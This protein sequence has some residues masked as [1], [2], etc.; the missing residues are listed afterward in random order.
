MAA[1]I[2]IVY[3]DI[4]DEITSAASRIRAAQ[5]V[6]VALVLPAGSRLATSRINFRLLAREAQ[7]RSRQLLIVA[8]EGATRALAASAGLTVFAT[9]RELEEAD[10]TP[11][12]PPAAGAGT[13]DLAGMDGAAGLAAAAGAAGLA[14]AAGAGTA[15]SSTA[16]PPGSGALGRGPKNAAGVQKPAIDTEP[17][18]VMPILA[19]PLSAGAPKRGAPAGRSA[20][21]DLPVAHG[22][23]R[24]KGPRTARLVGGVLLV[25]AALLGGV[26]G[27]V[28]LPSATI[29]LTPRVEAI[30]PLTFTVRADPSATT[31]DPAAATVPALVVTFPLSAS[32]DFPATGKKVTETKATGA[33]TFSSFDQT[34]SNTIPAG[35]IVS[36]TSDTEFV[37]A[38]SVTLPP[39]TVVSDGKLPPTFTI[40]PSTGDSKV[41]AAKAGTDG[42]VPVGSIRVVPPSENAVVTKVTNRSATSGGTHTETPQVQQKDIDK[43]TTTLTKQLS[44]QLDG[45]LADPTQVPEG[46]TVFPE[47]KAITTPTPAVDPATL[48]GG[49]EGTFTYEL[50]ATGSVTTVDVNAVQS[51]AQVRLRSSVTAGNSLVSG[52]IDVTVG[53]GRVQNGAIVFP[54]QATASQVRQVVAADLLPLVRGLGLEDAQA[55]LAPYGDATIDLWPGFVNRIPAY[56]F[57]ID[58]TVRASAAVEGPGASSSVPPSSG[59]T[60]SSPA[61]SS[62][63]PSSG[64][65][66]SGS[67]GASSDAGAGASPS[68]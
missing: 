51:V 4:D 2:A 9:V 37:T 64:S 55:A 35:S 56:D 20:A 34:R 40:V 42:N 8:P 39:A 23:G 1:S 29:V 21:A 28:F 63:I 14:D 11:G 58:I 52:S 36:T 46:A 3:L 33:V 12:G 54:V 25:S 57:R 53:K 60:G 41:T 49:L 45:I 68:P 38:N 43:A 67:S 59:A 22:D 6:R 61:A 16:S 17:T 31:P 62:A 10:E 30:T 27:Y 65:S 44:T 47:T 66:A 7:S 48:V 15:G 32:N 50:D 13:A 24:R 18:V 19:E 5:E 26:L